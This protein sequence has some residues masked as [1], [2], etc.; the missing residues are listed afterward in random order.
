M[1]WGIRTRIVVLSVLV[2]LVVWT[3]GSALLLWTLNAQLTANLEST[4][5]D[6]A[7]SASA[8]VEGWLRARLDTVPGAKKRIGVQAL[9]L[10]T[11]R[12]FFDD[13][14][15]VY[16]PPKDV[17][18]SVPNLM[19]LIDGQ[20]KIL[21]SSHSPSAIDAPPSELLASLHQGLTSSTTF[22]V[23]D[24]ESRQGVY[25]VVA[26]PVQ[27][28]GQVVASTLVMAPRAALDTT[29]I[30]VRNLLLIALG[31]A[32]LVNAVLVAWAVR[33]ALVP[34]DALVSQIHG[35]TDRNLSLR[36]KVPS[37]KDELRRL[38]ETFNEMLGRLESAFAFQTRLFQDLS[39]QLKTPLAI[40]TGTL[41]TALS[42]DRTAEE[43][44]S[45]LESN[46]DE[47]QRMA[48]LIEGL[49]LLARLD[50]HQLVLEKKTVDF[51]SWAQTYL[52]DFALLLEKRNLTLAWKVDGPVRVDVDV[53][54]IGQALLNL[55][56]NAV[57][58]SP[59]GGAIAIAVR[60]APPVAVLEITNQGPPFETGSEE[61]LFERF[62]RFNDETP[63]FGLGLPIAR[64]AVERH[65]GHLSAYSPAGGGAGFR[66]E[67]PL[68]F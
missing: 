62:S 22:H 3:A 30:Q 17:P 49:L 8:E 16:A 63:G 9:A 6:R 52:E 10:M 15:D 1:K 54:R 58:Y 21:L 61:R 34:V 19:I 42:Q 41:E 43:Y 67:L 37:A 32:V 59:E 65:G 60:S 28:S 29:M 47:V 25:R 50:S 36:V 14:A 12:S 20:G 38:A 26:Q 57:K 46:L 55:F 56:D 5:W 24:S 2:N 53:R 13:L 7:K 64:S 68:R 11:S 48:Q 31:A 18:S 40:L 51:G 4:L 27:V 23:W 45:T 35:V 44:Q 33:R 39:H 66:M